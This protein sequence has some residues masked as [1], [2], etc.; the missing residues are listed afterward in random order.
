MCLND[1]KNTERI[2][3]INQF[4]LLENVTVT[5]IFNINWSHDCQVID[6]EDPQAAVCPCHMVGIEPRSI[7]N[8][9]HH[10]QVDHHWCWVDFS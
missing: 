1:S 7:M 3:Q 6:L 9:N 10:Q 8:A 4:L 5:T 2:H